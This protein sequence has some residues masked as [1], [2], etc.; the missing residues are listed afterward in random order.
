MAIRR[1]D[2]PLPVV[3]D[4]LTAPFFAGAAR[5]ELVV[6]C[7]TGC[8]QYVWYPQERCPVCGGALEW[9][10]MCG[11]GT[12]FSWTVL[13]RVFLPEFED[14]VLFTSALISLAEYSAVRIIT[15]VVD[16]EPA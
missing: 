2:F 5:G 16:T 10:P 9:V 13:L 15:Y 12:L 1:A 8:E 14:M 11:R 3:D 7:C 4:P 6:T